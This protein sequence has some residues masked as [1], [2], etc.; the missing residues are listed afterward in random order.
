[1]LRLGLVAGTSGNVSAREGDLVQITPSG[2]P[3]PEM[4]V[5][6]LVTLGLDGAVVAGHREPSSERRVHLAVY[7]GRPDARALVHS[8]SVHA[9]AWSFLEE[10]LDTGTEELEDAAG[11]AVLT[12]PFAPTGSDE[13]AAA[14]LEALGSRRAVLLGRHGVLALG[15]SPAH[16]LDVCAAVERQAQVAWLLRGA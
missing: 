12:A 9:T 2:L 13:I 6:D 8:H 14:A 16:A 11:G 1:M 15:E 5:D 3:Y 4:T 7:A 10:P